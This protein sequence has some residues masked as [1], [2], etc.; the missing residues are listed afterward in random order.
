MSGYKG[1]ES[2]EDVLLTH[3][4]GAHSHCV[5][6]KNAPGFHFLGTLLAA[7]AVA[8]HVN[9]YYGTSGCCNV[10][11]LSLYHPLWMAANMTKRPPLDLP[12]C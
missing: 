7:L 11:A 10:W 8:A 2:S 1:L 9:G 3:L 5:D 12:R 6:T 4:K